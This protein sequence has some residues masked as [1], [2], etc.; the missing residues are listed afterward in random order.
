MSE[1]VTWAGISGE[2]SSSS[3]FDLGSPVVVMKCTVFT[4]SSL[5]HI[6][7]GLPSWRLAGPEI[8]DTP[9]GYGMGFAPII[10]DFNTYLLQVGL[11]QF[12]GGNLV[13]KSIVS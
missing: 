2:S 8:V 5:A 12:S 1:I 6:A 7:F 13:S 9:A 10:A 4:R 3:V 11:V